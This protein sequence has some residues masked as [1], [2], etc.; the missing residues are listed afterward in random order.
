MRLWSLHPQ[1]LD[2]KGLVAC[3]REGLLAKKVLAGETKGYRNHPQIYRFKTQGEPAA[4]IN[5]YLLGLF[6]DAARRGYSFNPQKIEQQELRPLMK[7]T[8]GQLV[9]ELGHLKSKLLVRDEKLYQGI[10]NLPQP[11]PHP[12]FEVIEGEV[13]GWEKINE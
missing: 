2:A 9:Y 6:L 4:L 1:Y 3:W 5:Q 7:V 10:L 12:L 8:V 13:E 11:I